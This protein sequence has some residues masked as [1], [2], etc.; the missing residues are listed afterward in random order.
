MRAS[1]SSW[2]NAAS[3]CSARARARPSD[4]C[5]ASSAS[6]SRTR[7]AASSVAHAC[8]RSAVST[9]AQQSFERVAAGVDF[10]LGRLAVLDDV[11]AA[12]G[13]GVTFAPH[14]LEAQALL[15][16][17]P[18]QLAD[19]ALAVEQS[20]RAAGGAGA[21][22]TMLPHL[23]VQ[24]HEAQLLVRGGEPGRGV[25]ILDHDDAPEQTLDERAIARLRAHQIRRAAE[26]GRDLGHARQR[27]R[28]RRLD[29]EQRGTAAGPRAQARERTVHRRRAVD[30]HE[31]RA[32]A[33]RG[34]DRVEEAR[35]DV[36]H[37]GEHADQAGGTLGVVEQRLHALGHAFEVAL[38]L[39]Q[40]LE[41][42]LGDRNV[43]T[44]RG[45]RRL[46]LLALDLDGLDR[47][48]DARE[49]LPR[50][51]QLELEPRGDASAVAS[52]WRP[53]SR[54]RCSISTRRA[55][56]AP[57]RSVSSLSRSRMRVA[58]PAPLGLGREQVE[59]E[60]LALEAA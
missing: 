3:S 19:L 54:S 15:G 18:G 59:R 60:L 53:R 52:R 57:R 56:T 36:E 11:L 1:L 47:G 7:S 26:H 37:L 21:H 39:E 40:G 31:R 33:E 34:L 45:P 8:S 12:R 14:R 4:S 51:V 46:A 13:D 16:D 24:A 44:R 9:L 48:D 35:G 28:H 17:E 41:P 38:E 55:S 43:P 42:R 30:Q 58:R 22:A 25:V 50:L 32:L 27:P 6:R 5:S 20:A 29:V 10:A 2:R 49:H 23:A